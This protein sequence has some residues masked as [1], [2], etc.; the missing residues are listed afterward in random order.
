MDGR[1]EI[2]GKVRF[3]RGSIS[4]PTGEP[5]FN[6]S[7]VLTD[8]LPIGTARP[9]GGAYTL[10]GLK[11]PIGTS[12]TVTLRLFSDGPTGGKWTVAV[13]KRSDARFSY[14]LDRTTGENGEKLHLTVTALPNTSLTDAGTSTIGRVNIESTK[15]KQYN[16]WPFSIAN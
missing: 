6:A 7:P 9:D 10:R 13:D 4:I 3:S 11:V 12:R 15:V 2:Q 16:S 1:P 8:D 14:A 5:Y